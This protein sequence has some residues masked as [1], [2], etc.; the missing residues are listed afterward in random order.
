MPR[1]VGPVY[2]KTFIPGGRPVP[3]LMAATTADRLLRLQLSRRGWVRFGQPLQPGAVGQVHLGVDRLQV[4]IDDTMVLDD[5]AN[6]TSPEGWWAAVDALGGHCV[7]VM[8][9]EGALDLAQPGADAQLVTLL[10]TDRAMSAALP[11]VTTLT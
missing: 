1:T 3:A 2:A 11:V 6:P 4:V 7:V 5:G 9:R 10:N 8:V